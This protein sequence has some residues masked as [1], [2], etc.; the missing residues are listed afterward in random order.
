VGVVTFRFRCSPGVILMRRLD[1][2]LEWR[3]VMVISVSGVLGNGQDQIREAGVDDHE[4]PG[5]GPLTRSGLQ[6]RPEPRPQSM[7]RKPRRR[8]RVSGT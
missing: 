6:Q 4:I 3:W 7:F 5:G 8:A 1:R 2:L